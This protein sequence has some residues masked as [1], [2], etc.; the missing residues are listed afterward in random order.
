M[1]RTPLMV[2]ALALLTA[3]G[4]D[5][6]APE[7]AADAVAT[8][9]TPSPAPANTTPTEIQAPPA[10]RLTSS[11]HE[12][13]LPPYTWCYTNGCVDGV[14]ATPPALAGSPAEVRIETPIA[15]WRLTATFS[16]TGRRCGRRQ[17]VEP[18][19]APDGSFVLRPAGPAGRYDVDLFAQGDG[20]DMVATFRWLTSLD[21]P[22]ATPAARLAV[23]A[24]HDGHP[25]SYG[26]ELAIDNLAR[27]PTE[28]QAHVAVTAANG[29]SVDFDAEH[30]DNAGCLPEGSIYFDG[31][32]DDG[33]RAAALGPA[34]F[35]YTVTL[36]L[37][38]RTYRASADYPDDVIAG[39]EPSVS[40]SFR[41]PLPA[42]S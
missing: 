40:L 39:N 16:P 10:F 15:G 13:Q 26:V 9:A 33:K 14:R 22:L 42:L 31:P 17:I 19:R 27:T 37:D 38:G 41:P 21:G 28:S 34:P 6:Q 23:I 35:T 29:R 1:S 2:A 7:H 36:V 11:G 4:T 3:C 24:D 5:R 20:G 32:D 8:S 18:T 25:D 12:L 30:A